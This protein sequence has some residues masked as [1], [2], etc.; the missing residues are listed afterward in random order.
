MIGNRRL[1]SAVVFFGWL[2]GWTVSAGAQGL[3]EGPGKAALEASCTL[4]HGLSYIT[5]SS[6]SAS[7]WRDVV[8]DMISRGAPLTLEEFE[9][10][11]QYLPTHFGPRNAAGA[12]SVNVNR[13]TAKELET[14]LM[15]STREA[16]AIV[17]YRGQNPAFRT[18]EDLKKVPGI[19][20]Q[21]IEAGKDRLTF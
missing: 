3:P 2:A 19:D 7:D 21:K 10:V 4:C 6:R 14:A 20:A 13:A 8:S 9:M 15:I 1:V 17:R 11:L 12:A 18:V 5:Q 16:E